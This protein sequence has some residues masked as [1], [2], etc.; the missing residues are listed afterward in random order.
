MPITQVVDSHASSPHHT[1]R[2]P[3]PARHR[4]PAHRIEGNHA[5]H[6]IHVGL[7]K[8]GTLDVTWR[9]RVHHVHVLHVVL[10]ARARREEHHDSEADCGAA[11]EARHAGE[12]ANQL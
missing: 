10:G 6:S 12:G 3:A 1:H 9:R 5:G 8:R 4:H 11:R 2:H 7:E